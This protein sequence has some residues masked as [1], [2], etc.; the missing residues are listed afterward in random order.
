MTSAMRGLWPRPYA[1]GISSDTCAH[2]LGCGVHV[3]SLLAARPA[4]MPVPRSPKMETD[5]S[6]SSRRAAVVISTLP[7][8]K[9]K[10]SKFSSRALHLHEA[11]YDQQLVKRVEAAAC[12]AHS[13]VARAI[14]TCPR[15]RQVAHDPGGSGTMKACHDSMEVRSPPS[16]THRPSGFSA[17]RCPPASCAKRR[18]APA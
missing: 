5:A 7:I 17:D 11:S 3:T 15:I 9:A 18:A 16:A 10:V 12:P 2:K 4:R 14:P 1:F 6:K 13:Q 8:V